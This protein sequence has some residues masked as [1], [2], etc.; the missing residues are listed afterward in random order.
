MCVLSLI[1][2][3]PQYDLLHERVE[4]YAGEARAQLLAL[5]DAVQYI[6]VLARVALETEQCRR[7]LADAEATSYT[8]EETGNKMCIRDSLND[9][10]AQRRCAR[11]RD[12]GDADGLFCEYYDG[13]VHGCLLYTS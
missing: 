13:L 7:A 5:N 10:H 1:H 11:A 4:L 6:S 8:D 3:Y 12:G 9:V 2:I